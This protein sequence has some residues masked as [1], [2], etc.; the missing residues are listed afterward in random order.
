MRAAYPLI[1]SAVGGVMQPVTRRAFLATSGITTGLGLLGATAS[2]DASAQTTIPGSS[3]I[4]S[5]FNGTPIRGGDFVWFTAVM[6]VQGLGG[7]PATIGFTGSL[8]FVAD[9]TTYMVPVPTAVVNFVPGTTAATASFCNGQWVT[10][11]PTSGLAGN[12]F[13]D[14]AA[15][16]APMPSGFPGGIKD[17]TWQGTLD[18]KSTR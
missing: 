17:V 11:V 14:G 6:K 18:R 2:R 15:I 8:S 3:T 4:V 12:V 13:L 1:S 10:T 5:N 9:G 16:Q 7:G